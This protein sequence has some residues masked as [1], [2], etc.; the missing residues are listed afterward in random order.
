MLART[1]SLSVLLAV[2]LTVGALAQSQEPVEETPP[3]GVE[4]LPVDLFTTENFYFDKEYWFDPRY[5]RCNTPFQLMDMVTNRRV[6]KWGDCDVDRPVEDIVSPYEYETAE[7]HY[8]ALMEKAEANGG[9]TQ[10]TRA[11]MPVFDG[12]YRKA[13]WDPTTREIDLGDQWINGHDAQAA[14]ILSLLT[15]EYQ[16]RMVQLMYHEAVT[17]APQWSASFCYPEGFLRWWYVFATR[18]IEVISTPDQVQFLAGVADNFVRKI[19][20]GQE[21]V[22]KVPQWYGETVGFWD[23]ETLIAWTKNVQGWQMTHSMFEFSN[24]MQTVEVIRQSEDGKHLITETTFYDPEALTQPLTMTA[25]WDKIDDIDSEQRYTFVECRP[26]S[27][28]VNG[29]DGRPTQLLPFD[30]G[31]IDFF[32]R[33]WAQHWEE[34]FEKGWKHPEE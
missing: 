32:G 31:Y 9:P 16:E 21:H 6:G 23:G 27:Q 28:I 12:W 22:Q 4:P 5:T 24:Q 34:Y 29:P 3:P 30:E 19:L 18:R 1:I 7:E 10:Y 25:R 15:P 26:T 17:N 13:G 14:T 2:G 33:P 11:T 8:N 20:I